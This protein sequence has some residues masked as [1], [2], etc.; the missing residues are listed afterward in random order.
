M[1]A[2]TPAATPPVQTRLL[3]VRG[4]VQGVGFRDG[5]LRHAQSLGIAGWVRN[6]LDGSVEALVHGPAE[7]LDSFERWL[8]H[9]VAAARV[10][11]VESAAVAMP[12]PAPDTFV[13][14]PTA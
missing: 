8:P 1:H 6:R 7:R 12:D 11:A 2:A 10:L 3:R 14:R 13:R 9:G 4:R 5:C